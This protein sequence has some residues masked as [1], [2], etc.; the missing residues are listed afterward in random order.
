[1]GDRWMV[2]SPC[3]LAAA[4]DAVVRSQ[5][6]GGPGAAARAGG[7]PRPGE[8]AGGPVGG[9]VRPGQRARL[10]RLGQV[11]RRG[12]RA[13]RPRAVRVRR[14]VG[15]PDGGGR[16]RDQRRRCHPRGG[17]GPDA[18]PP[19]NGARRGSG[20]RGLCAVRSTLLSAAT[21]E[22]RGRPAR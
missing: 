13:R 19:P 5:P 9:H 7:R 10:R 8:P 15:R 20:G 17:H 18:Q 16:A 14:H 6:R 2:R 21:T 22:R 4:R 1:M 3:Q 11:P 12:R